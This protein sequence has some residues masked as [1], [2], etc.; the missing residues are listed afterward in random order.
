MVGRS[1]ELRRTL[2]A[3]IVSIAP[4]IV[5]FAVLGIVLTA[6]GPSGLD[7]SAA[8]TSG[9]IAML[10]GLPTL[11]ALI[12]T[13]RYRDAAARHRGHLRDHLLR[14]A[15]PPG[16]P[17]RRWWARRSSPGAVVLAAAVLGLTTLIAE[18]IP[19]PIVY[20]LIAGAVMPFVAG[21]FTSL[22]TSAGRGRHPGRGPGDDRG[23]PP[24]IPPQ[25]APVRH[26]G[27]ADPRGVRCRDRWWRR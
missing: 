22:S 24:R 2:P 25:P 7:L 11:I 10:Y 9:W 26:A 18:W 4:T 12:L 1:S 21:V 14:L 20:G 6:A 16:S 23:R 17:S 5:Y 3:L 13:L 19:A 27:A 15:R 8:E